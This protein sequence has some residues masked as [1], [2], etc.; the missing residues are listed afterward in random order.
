M[1][2]FVFLQLSFKID[3]VISLTFG[4]PVAYDMPDPNKNIILLFI[5]FPNIIHMFFYFNIPIRSFLT[6][7]TYNS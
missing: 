5:L 7:F 1:F 3:I 6:F 4:I 2:L